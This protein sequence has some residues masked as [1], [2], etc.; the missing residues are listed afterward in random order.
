[1][2]ITVHGVGGAAA[3]V[4]LPPDGILSRRTRERV[5][6]KLRT[7]PGLPGSG[8]LG[9][10]GP[11]RPPETPG[12]EYTFAALPDERVQATPCQAEGGGA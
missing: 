9:E 12:W 5:Q 1:M 7:P 8:P 10:V 2:R 3:T 4:N 6:R 11:Q